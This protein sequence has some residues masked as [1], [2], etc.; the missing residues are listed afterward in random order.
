MRHTR[1][2]KLRQESAGQ[3]EP[4][5][6]AAL[7][8]GLIGLAIWACIWIVALIGGLIWAFHALGGGQ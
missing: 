3:A 6:T 7:T 1:F 4:E 8:A 2:S 5:L